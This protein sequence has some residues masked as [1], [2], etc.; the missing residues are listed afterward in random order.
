MRLCFSY[1]STGA[2]ATELSIELYL[3][4]IDVVAFLV[5]TTIFSTNSI[6]Q[7]PSWEATVPQ[8]FRK[9]SSCYGT[10]KFI[11]VFTTDRHLH[12]SRGRW[13]I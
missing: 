2:G 13:T 6:K 9:F 10:K 5:R 7:R 8:L 1:T 11:N 3:S 12:L 4:I